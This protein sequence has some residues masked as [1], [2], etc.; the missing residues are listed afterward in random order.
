MPAFLLHDLLSEL[1]EKQ[2]SYFVEIGQQKQKKETS[3]ASN[4][5]FM[6]CQVSLVSTTN[7]VFILLGP[8]F[9]NSS[10]SSCFSFDPC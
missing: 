7:N 3:S 9:L 2:Q 1:P 4:S 6:K 8:G 5:F 10:L